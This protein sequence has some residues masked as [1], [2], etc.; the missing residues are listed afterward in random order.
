MY[1]KLLPRPHKRAL[2][3][4]RCFVSRNIDLLVLAFK[5]YVRHLLEYNSV[6]WSPS[7]IQD[8]EAIESVQR[9]FAK[10]LYGLHSLPYKSRL[11]CLNLQSLEH[12]RLLTDLVWCYK[13]VFGLVVVNTMI[14]L[15]SLL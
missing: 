9:R 8:I 15:N 7:T 12:R 11:Q 5:V 3:I 13:I 1:V 2:L 10:R 14:S 6:I 4:H